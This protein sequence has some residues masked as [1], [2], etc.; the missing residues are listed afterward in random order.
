MPTLNLSRGVR[1]QPDDPLDG[2]GCHVVVE[3]RPGVSRGWLAH[4]I[5]GGGRRPL[6][7]AREVYHPAQDLRL[8]TY[9]DLAGGTY[10]AHSALDGCRAHRAVFAVEDGLIC[11]AS[12]RPDGGAQLA[13][14]DP[15]R[16]PD[17]RFVEVVPPTRTESER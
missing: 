2:P 1:H 10:E 17:G 7:P 13:L 6:A 16:R 14:F 15:C 3:A 5:E 4:L 8:R 12:P 11:L 9:T